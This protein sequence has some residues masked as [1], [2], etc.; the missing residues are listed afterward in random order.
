MS[1]NALHL[2]R[3]VAVALENDNARLTAGLGRVYDL[4]MAGDPE[5]AVQVLAP[6][7]TQ[8]PEAPDNR[9]RLWLDGRG[10]AWID[11]KPGS[12][13]VLRITT[14]TTRVE[15]EDAD[16]VR[17]LTGSLREIGRTW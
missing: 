11:T 14:T 12:D 5:G 15:V 4:L 8:D 10:G 13:Q 3:D 9:H 16:M 1:D 17:H 7:A 6:L 2:A